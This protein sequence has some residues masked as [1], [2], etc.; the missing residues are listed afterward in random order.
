MSTN[1]SI[2]L[3]PGANKGTG[4]AIAAG[5]A[6]RGFIV[7]LGARNRE[8]GIAAASELAGEGD[9]RALHLDV[10]DDASVQAVA[11]EVEAAFG[12]DPLSLLEHE[13][14]TAWGLGFARSARVGG[15]QRARRPNTKANP[16]GHPLTIATIA[17]SLLEHENPSRV[18]PGFRP[19]RPG[20][21]E[22][23]S[24]AAN[25]LHS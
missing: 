18:G 2:A 7:L 13:T 21:R 14:Q 20:G 5:L 24:A 1:N 10:T 15:N 3:V 11:R 4:K 12:R 16:L 6:K 8:R 9:V 25:A 19:Q 23:K 17:L 22:P